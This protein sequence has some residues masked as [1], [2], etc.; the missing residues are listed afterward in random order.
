LYGFWK[1]I[2][3]SLK[4]ACNVAVSAKK[5]DHTSSAGEGHQSPDLLPET[6]DIQAV[7]GYSSER[8]WQSERKN[9]KLT[10]VALIPVSV[11]KP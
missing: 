3:A 4:G 11:L 2:N 10:R 7:G 6:P 1:T 9:E 8:T 5:V